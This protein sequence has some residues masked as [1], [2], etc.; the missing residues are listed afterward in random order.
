MSA[1]I[2]RDGDAIV[3]SRNWSA[4]A[5]LARV[6]EATRLERTPDLHPLITHIT[7]LATHGARSEC[8]VHET[9]PLGPLRILNSYRAT[10][11]LI[12][13]TETQARLV[14]DAAAALGTELRHDL[15]LRGVGVRTEVTHIVRVRAPRLLRSF[16]ARTAE[17]AHDAWV[18]RVCAWAEHA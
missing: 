2:T 9:V 10:R 15:T 18:E 14:L 12:E 11:E 6:L 3:F 17:R 5:P 13:A 16:V 4:R 7:Q 8:V 1:E